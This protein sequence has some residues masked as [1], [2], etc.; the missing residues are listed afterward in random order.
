MSK[1][2]TVNDVLAALDKVE[3]PELHASLVSLH[4]VQNIVIEDGRVAFDLILTTPACPLK[5][6]IEA[7]ARKAVMDLGVENVE[8][9][10]KSVIQ[11]DPRRKNKEGLK[12]KN[13]IAI[14]SGKGGVG[15]STLAVNLALALTKMGTK[16]GL[17]DADIYGPNTHTMLGVDQIPEP[18]NG[19][20]VPAEKFNLKLISIGLLVDPKQ[21]LIW[22]GPM[23]H[24][25]IKQFLM[26]VA[27][28]ELDYL[29]VDMP[30][31]TGDAQISLSQVIEVTAG[32]IVTLPQKVSVDDARRA[33]NM[34]MQLS[35]PIIGVVENMSY[36]VMPDGSKNAI[37]GEGGGRNLANELA[38]PFLGALP[39]DPAIRI[40]GDNGR[41][42]IQYEENSESAR[43][44]MDIACQ[45][46]AALCK[47]QNKK[48][49]TS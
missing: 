10:L 28:G 36:L 41:P 43:M 1:K 9:T 45:L 27:W 20:I 17:M 15:K 49:Q 40:G 35:I 32:V 33:A 25:A 38:V 42:I 7:S 19:K 22:R 2:L 3:E 29:I 23:L 37:F 21:P 14:A 24:S 5:G 26:D 31:G 4:M 8:I 48:D 18:A 34:F 46:S 44:I 16:V 6:Q 47:L 11:E 12:I 13:I 30:P 39:I